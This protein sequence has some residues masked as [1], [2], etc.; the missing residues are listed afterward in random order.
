MTDLAASPRPRRPRRFDPDRK[1][2]IIDAA[3]DVIA[4]HGVR[5]TTHRLIAAAADVPL[6]SLTYHFDS[7]DDLLLQAFTRHAALMAT[8]YERHFDG[9]HTRD[10]LVQAI[11]NLVLGADADRDSAI[12]FEL[13]LAAVHNPALRSVTQG[14][15]ESSRAVL[16]RYLD[17]VT[18]RGVD[19]LIEGLIIHSILSTA[20]V[21]RSDTIGYIDRALRQPVAQ[22][23]TN[24]AN[25][26]DSN[27]GQP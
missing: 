13:Y 26:S 23:V 11:A 3:L 10:D 17:P 2:R 15:M 1:D 12:N 8:A 16:H 21:E 18:A 27:P 24:S 14:W 25:S 9:V 4:D 5:G 20:P 7:L 19:A 22:P 6:G